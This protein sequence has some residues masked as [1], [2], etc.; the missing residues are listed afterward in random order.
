MGKVIKFPIKPEYEEF[1]KLSRGRMMALIETLTLASNK[2]MLN[3]RTFQYLIDQTGI[4]PYKDLTATDLEIVRFHCNY[5]YQL[6][7]ML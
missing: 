1:I 2:G 3:D 6:P 5:Y 4:D 7:N